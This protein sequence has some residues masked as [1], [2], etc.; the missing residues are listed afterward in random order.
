MKKNINYLNDTTVCTKTFYIKKGVTILGL[1]FLYIA[2]TIYFN[3][4]SYILG[5]QSFGYPMTLKRFLLVSCLLAGFTTVQA[6]FDVQFSQYWALT[7]YYNPAYAGQNDKLNIYG[8]YSMQLLGFTNAPKSM[9]FGADMPFKFLNKR[10]GVGIGFFNEGIG[11]FRNQ[12]FWAQYSY[13]LKLFGGNLGIG[14]QIGALNISFDPA[15]INLGNETDT[16]DPAFPSSQADGLGLDVD[17]GLYYTHKLFYAGFSA[18]HLNAPTVR[19]GDNNEIK[20]D[21]TLYFT[22]G[23]NIKTKNPLISIQPSI[24]LKTDMVSTKVDLTG[25]VFYKWNEK[26]FYAGLS[27]SPTSSIAILLGTQIKNVNI[28]YAYD[29]FTS[30]IGAGSGSHDLFVSY[31]MDMNFFGKSKNKHK[32]I[33]IL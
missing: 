18:T 29:M 33:R 17:A 21:P 7:G 31:S 5:K 27:Y 8:T 23:C 13:K 6:Q 26:T 22:A 12:R 11:L 32:S 30:K 20:I 19:L 14:V 25:R 9:Y 4:N 10:H 28:G 24:L 2:Y 1:P 3:F 16:N 15:D